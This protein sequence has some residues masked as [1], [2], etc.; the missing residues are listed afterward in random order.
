MGYYIQTK[1]N[2][3]KAEEIAR[4]HGGK[5]VDE[6]TAGMTMMDKDFA[7]IVVINNGPFEAAGFAFDDDEFK[8]FTALDDPRPRKFVILDRDTAKELT[9]YKYD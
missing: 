4:E 1:D 7:V 8:A 6:L 5:I 2:H 3:G 9:G